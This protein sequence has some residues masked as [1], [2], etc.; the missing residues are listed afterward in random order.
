MNIES[1]CDFLSKTTPV[2]KKLI[3]FFSGVLNK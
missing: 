2:M 3:A 1:K